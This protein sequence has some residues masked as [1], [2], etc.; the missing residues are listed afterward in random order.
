MKITAGKIVVEEMFFESFLW[1]Y[2][3][4]IK[5]EKHEQMRWRGDIVEKGVADIIVANIKKAQGK[6]EKY[7]KVLSSQV[8]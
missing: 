2:V 1:L 6:S 8:I 5:L 3:R 7:Y 4:F